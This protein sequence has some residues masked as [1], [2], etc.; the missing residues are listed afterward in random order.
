MVRDMRKKQNMEDQISIQ[1]VDCHRANP[2]SSDLTEDKYLKYG[3]I[4][5]LT[6]DYRRMKITRTDRGT[7]D[8]QNFSTQPDE[9]CGFWHLDS[10]DAEGNNARKEGRRSCYLE[11]K[12]DRLRLTVP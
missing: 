8:F 12:F 11:V 4:Q 5:Y 2:A 9:N 3:K 7:S 10:M 1:N 6:I